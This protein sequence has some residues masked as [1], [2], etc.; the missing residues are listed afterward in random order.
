MN[1][2][3]KLSKGSQDSTESCCDFMSS[4]LSIQNANILTATW[5]SWIEESDP[6]DWYFKW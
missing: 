2:K 3:A 6:H 1:I 5:V 4:Y